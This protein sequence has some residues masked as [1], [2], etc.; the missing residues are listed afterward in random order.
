MNANADAVQNLPAAVREKIGVA[1]YQR[2]ADCEVNTVNV[3]GMLAAVENA[4]SLFWQREEALALVGKEIAPCSMLSTWGR[5]ERW[6]PAAGSEIKPLQLHYDLKTL[7]G[8]PTAIV[9]S[10]ESVFHT[11]AV[12]GDSVSTQQVLKSVSEPKTTKLGTGRFWLIEMQY[13][14]QHGD[15]L[16]IDSFNCFGYERIDN[17]DSD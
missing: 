1:C 4:S 11:P 5:P 6:S 15:L 12:I 14:N 8:F 16:G 13:R 17:H 9:S 10:F 2:G 3:H 7:F